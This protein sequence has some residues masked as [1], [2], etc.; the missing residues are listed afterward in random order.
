MVIEQ[1]LARAGGC[2]RLRD[3]RGGPGTDVELARLVREQ[4]VI[5]VGHG[6]YALPGVPAD[7]IAAR[8]VGGLVSCVSLVGYLGLPLLHKADAPHVAVASGRSTAVAKAVPPG[9]VIHRARALEL[10]GAPRVRTRPLAPTPLALVQVMQCLP[11]RESVAV[12]DAALNRRDCTLADIERLRPRSG[13]VAFDRILRAVDGRAQ[14]LPESILR[15]G[16]RAAGLAVEPQIVILGLGRVDLLVE[17][18]VI[19]EVDGMAYHSDRAQFGEDRRRDRVACT[20]RI[21]AL[22]YT[23]A[24][25]VHA[26]A[27]AVL[28]VTEVVRQLCVR[29]EPRIPESYI[30]RPMLRV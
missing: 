8:A 26:T 22:R 12:I 15:L 14:S 5:R 16:L 28:E 10:P 18:R 30:R 11:F 19:V 6:L 1:T 25:A 4:R 29:G 13:R 24:D 2:L 9:T 21:P 27:R 17:R 3:I 7:V 23:Y 20:L